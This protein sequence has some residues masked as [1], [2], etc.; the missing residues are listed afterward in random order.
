MAVASTVA[1]LAL[2]LAGCGGGTSGTTASSGTGGSATSVGS[3]GSTGATPQGEPIVFGAIVSTTGPA[4]ALGEQEQKTLAM[5]QTVINGKGGVL[6]RP[7]KI[8]VLDDKSDPQQAVTDAN[9]LLQQEKAIA[10]IG[11]TGSPATLAI[12]QI[13]AEK[14][15][16]QM[17]MAAANDIT[18]KP[19]IDWIWRLPAKDAVA[20]AKALTYIQNSLKVKKI[21][22]LHDENAFGSSGA[23]EIVKTVGQHGL[24][25]VA[26]ESYKTADTDL[27]SQLTKIKGTNPEAIVVWGT[28]PGPALAAKNM[29][30]LGITIP[31]IGSHGIANRTFIQLAADAAEGVVFPAGKLLIPSSITDANQKQVTDDFVKLYSF[32]YGQPPNTFA[33]HA[34]DA[35]NLLV[36]AITKTGST[37]PADIQKALNETTGFAGP[38]GIYNYSATNHDGLTEDD[39]IM[40]KIENGNW[41]QLK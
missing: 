26:N 24:E 23:A 29:K 21:A 13:T 39:M 20:V 1:V 7:L 15:I 11:S 8:V 38:D 25:I 10:I 22:I 34:L 19:P 5:L 17:A 40:V 33:G 18:D 41:V 35:V 31:Y 32:T 28:N 16:P 2:I 4:S 30:Q 14:G 6:G 27:T 9:Q 36:N 12:K 37:K 3:T